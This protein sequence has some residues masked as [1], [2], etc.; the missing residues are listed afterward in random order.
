MVATLKIK[1]LHTHPDP[2]SEAPEGALTAADNIVVDKEGL[3]EKRRGFDKL[4]NGFATTTERSNALFFFDDKIL[5]HHAT[6]KL[7]YT[8]ED[9]A[10]LTSISTAI[11]APDTD[12]PV[13]GK[14]A[15]SNLYLTSDEGIYKLPAF[16]GSLTLAG[17]PQALEITATVGSSGSGFLGAS[18]TT[19]YR[20]VWGI[21]DSNDNLILGAP[22]GREEVTNS[23]GTAEDVSIDFSIPDT[24]TTSYFYQIYRATQVDSGST[25]SDELGLIYEANPTSG[26]ITAGTITFSDTVDDSLIGTTIYTAPSQETIS[27]SNYQPPLATDIEVYQEYTFFANIQTKYRFNLSMISVGSPDGV[28][29]DDTITIDGVVYT[30]KSAESVANAQFKVTTSGS[31]SQNIEDTAKSLVKII[32]Q[33][34]SSLV[35]AYY[36]S[37]P[38]DLPGKIMLEERTLSS[39]G[40]NTSVSRDESWLPAGLDT[41]DAATNDDFANGIM[42]SKRQQP[43]HVPLTNIFRVGSA[44]KKILRIK[45]LRE[46]LLI[47]KEEGIWRL[48]GNSDATFVVNRLDTSTRLWARESV[49]ELNNRVFCLTDQGVVAVSDGGVSVMSR[50]IE[51]EFRTLQGNSLSNLQSLSFGIG[52][53][54]ERKYILFTPNAAADTY[55]TQAYVYNLFTNAWTKWQIEAVSGG[56]NPVDD[57]CYL[58]D[59]DSEFILQEL[60]SLGSTDFLDFFYDD[61]IST[62]SDLTLTLADVNANLQAGDYIRQGANTIQILTVDEPNNQITI[63]SDPGFTTAAC[64]LHKGIDCTLTWTVQT[65]NAPHLVKH[66]TSATFMFDR[67]FAQS[68]DIVFSSD[69]NLSSDSTTVSMTSVTSGAWGDEPWGDFP[70]GGDDGARKNY[71]IIVPSNKQRC[72]QLTISYQHNLGLSDFAVAGLSLEG[73]VVSPRAGA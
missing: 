50:P 69:P 33:H 7:S 17:A 73:D 65:E 8:D 38:D 31:V 60:K 19:V 59:A 51:N 47:F 18:K 26:E 70:W 45:A 43:E 40:F 12:N 34:S 61:S 63:A 29:V 10:A 14:Q 67:S 68:A 36:M 30:G 52:Y 15:N 23:G 66:Y 48:T 20:I 44:K 54:S 35:Y 41:A 5:T 39:D 32:N 72:N 71:R 16:N 11:T 24:I 13:R 64:E 22:S 58:G 21:K 9:G 53:E 2:L 27:Q 46:S 49:V 28:Q 6:A 42:F 62:I 3:A 1:G 55:A 56:V 37:G 57:K 4:D 25:P